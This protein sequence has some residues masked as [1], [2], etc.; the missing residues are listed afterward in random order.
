M[1]ADDHFTMCFI[2]SQ[3][4]PQSMLLCRGQGCRDNSPLLEPD[5]Q[6]YDKTCFTGH[7]NSMNGLR[8]SERGRERE[9]EDT[10]CSFIFSNLFMASGVWLDFR[11]GLAN[12]HL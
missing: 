4:L 10:R 8:E 7:F 9:R 6:T 12:T 11:V 2:D 3:A 5:A 1:S